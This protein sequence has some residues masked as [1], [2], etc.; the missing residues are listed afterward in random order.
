MLIELCIPVHPHL[1]FVRALACLQM[2]EAYLSVA[3]GNLLDGDW[4]PQ[5]FTEPLIT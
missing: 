5:T 1:S 3:N 4:T 2:K